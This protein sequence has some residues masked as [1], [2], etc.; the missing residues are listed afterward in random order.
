MGEV[1][2]E[3]EI[4]LMIASGTVR[5]FM[6]VPV[7]SIVVAEGLELIRPSVAIRVSETGELG[8]LH[9]DDSVSF[10]VLNL[11]SESFVGSFGKE[12]PLVVTNAPDSGGA[13]GHDDRSIFGYGDADGL[14]ELVATVKI[15]GSNPG[16]D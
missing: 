4:A 8:L 9:D 11:N 6:V 12:G 10:V 14:E 15:F 5:V 3:V 2:R 13:G 1:E 7:E 16:F